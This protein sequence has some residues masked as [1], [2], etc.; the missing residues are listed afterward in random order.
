MECLEQPDKWRMGY[1]AL[2]STHVCNTPFRLQLWPSR[3]ALLE[4]AQTSTPSASGRH[5]ITLVVAC[6]DRELTEPSTAS[7]LH[8]SNP[9]SLTA[10]RTCPSAVAEFPLLTSVRGRPVAGAGGTELV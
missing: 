3:V 10:S 1:Y 2:E 6:S 8:Y 9:Q 7:H 5:S 4:A